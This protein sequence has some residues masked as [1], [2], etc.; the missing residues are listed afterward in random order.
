MTSSEAFLPVATDERA[1]LEVPMYSP[2]TPN[3]FT[4]ASQQQPEATATP[5]VGNGEQ[6]LYCNYC[7]DTRRAVLAV[8]VVSIVLGVI[9]LLIGNVLLNFIRDHPDEF[10]EGAKMSEG[11]KQQ[12][13]EGLRMGAIEVDKAVLDSL[14]LVFITMHG[15]GI[16]GAL[17]FKKWAVVT[18]GSAYV[19]GFI[20][21]LLTGSFVNLIVTCALGYPHYFFVKEINQGV[22]SDYNYHNV[23][24]CCGGK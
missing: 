2:E 16:Y 14:S 24:H 4:M 11:E 22:M 15:I 21:N 10:E 5:V 23:A 3:E 6:H 17:K 12:F 1:E 19:I 20:L 7:C 18:A 13:E 8:N 9:S